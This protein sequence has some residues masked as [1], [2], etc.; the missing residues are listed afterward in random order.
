MKNL[1]HKT[2][3]GKDA[4]LTALLAVGLLI[5]V[6]LGCS[7]LGKS[8]SSAPI[9][10]I[11]FGS[12]TGSDGSTITIRGD[13]K[14]DYKSGGTTVDG[15]TVA[16]DDAK[17]ELSITFFGIGPT[18]KIDSPPT[19]DEMKLDGIVYRRNGGFST[20]DKTTSP[21]DSSNTNSSFE[22]KNGNVKSG[23][24]T[25]DAPSDS[26]VE[27]LVK[28][29]LSDFADGVDA[30]DFTDFRAKTSKDFQLTY[31]PAQVTE[32]FKVF[33]NQK[34]KLVPVLETVNEKSAAFSPKPEVTTQKGANGKDYRIL[35]A[36][37]TFPTSQTT[38][39]DITY[40]LE[41]G[42]WKVLKIRIQY[43]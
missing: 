18:L 2:I 11:Y 19:A 36:V 8:S 33:I 7:K 28:A 12:W 25:G 27:S 14:G 26:E 1:L 37:G 15:G 23:D 34:D 29:T 16:V 3:F 31:N 35:S 13:G 5:F 40:V 6:G 41:N 20:S 9:P 22:I 38:N 32:L 39:F 17:K 10:A 4:S 21:N 43:F 24:S 30:G 42:K